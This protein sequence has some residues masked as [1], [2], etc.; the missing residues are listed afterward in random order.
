MKH[1]PLADELV[2]TE[3]G[4]RGH[5]DAAGGLRGAFGCPGGTR[6]VAEQQLVRD[7]VARAVVDRLTADVHQRRGR[8]SGVMVHGVTLDPFHALEQFCAG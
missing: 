1:G 4:E 7:D 3:L 5:D 8:I 6:R 2:E